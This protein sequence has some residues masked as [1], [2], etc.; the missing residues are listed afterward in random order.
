MNSDALAE[1]LFQ[2]TI[3]ALEMYAVY[4]GDQLGYYRV[5]ASS[6]WFTA[7]DLAERS[8]TAS[9]YCEEWLSHQAVREI[10]EV[11]DVRAQPRRYRLPAEHVPVLA[12][13]DSL[14]NSTGNALN[15]ARFGRRLPELV[16]AY[17][18]GNAPPAMPWGPEG[19]AEA[20]RAVFLNLLG[21]QWLPSIP[22][23]DQR[24]RVPGARI[25]DIACG[26]G[27][28]SVAMAQAY[29]EASVDGIDL[30]GDAIEEAKRHARDSGVADRVRFVAGDAAG[31]GAGQRY[32][33]VTIIE[34][35]H[36]MAQPVAALRAVREA[37]ADSGSVLVI[38]TRTEDEFTV[39][40]TAYEQ[41]EFGWSL[42]ACLPDA[43]EP[44]SA[45]TGMVMRP[46]TLRRYA[47]EAGFTE[48]RV[49][50]IDTPYWRFYELVA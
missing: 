5:M 3:G 29:R 45:A 28:S 31:F 46:S 22:E 37:L 19:R 36:D 41:L 13:P 43:M 17:R 7:D 50:P 34:A 49:L 30:D 44:G 21:K 25:A 4:L 47:A 14:L 16:E 8:G 39:P 20:N 12:D 23:L 2:D 26:T 15:L 27:W 24:L 11:Q 32:D 35:L 33:L 48:V 40:G 1:R 10:V 42:L 18:A 6:D 38:D 9:R